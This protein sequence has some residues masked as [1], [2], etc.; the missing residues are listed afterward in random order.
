MPKCRKARLAG[1]DS[2]TRFRPGRLI[3][4]MSIPMTTA[5]SAITT[6]TTVRANTSVVITEQETEKSLVTALTLGY[7]Q[8][9]VAVEGR[10]AFTRV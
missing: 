6:T 1:K 9:A 4:R 3:T 7:V 10:A 2:P 8:T 5:T